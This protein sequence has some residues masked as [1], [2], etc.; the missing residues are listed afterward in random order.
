MSNL[1]SV[2]E[3][4]KKESRAVFIGLRNAGQSVSIRGRRSDK[5]FGVYKKHDV[6][7]LK[8]RVEGIPAG[9]IGTVMMVSPDVPGKIL[10]EFPE[11]NE[12]EITL[13]EINEADVEIVTRA[14]P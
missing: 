12:E 1:P 4:K 6:I 2:F 10:V 5:I 7:R 9:A 8:R 11:W 3:G 14:R 13:V